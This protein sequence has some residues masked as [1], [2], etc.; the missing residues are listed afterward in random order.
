MSKVK[1][2]NQYV[3]SLGVA[4]VK[5]HN[6]HWNVVGMEFMP[7]HLKTEEIYTDFFAKYDEVAEQL[8]IQGEMPLATFA[9]Y[10]EH[11]IIKEVEPRAFKVKEVL[12]IVIED[13]ERMHALAVDIRKASE[14]ENDFSTVAMFEAHINYYSKELW[15]LKAMIQG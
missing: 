6:L 9:A 15:F 12:E 2:M 1:L 13:L 14:D 3:A 11:S 5:L 10:L 4:N 7:V 8:K